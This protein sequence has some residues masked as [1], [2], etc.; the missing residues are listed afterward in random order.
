MTLP[1]IAVKRPIGTLMALVSVLVLGIIALVKLELAFMPEQQNKSLFVIANYQ[2]ASPKAIERMIVKPIEEVLASMNGVEHMWSNADS[3]GGRVVLNFS[4][5][6]NIDLARAEIHER[7]DRIKSELPEDLERLVIAGNWNPRETGET[8]M[9]ARLSSGRDLSKNYELLDRK[10]VKP[11]ERIPGVAV[12]TLDGVNPREVRIN[13]DLQ[14]LKRHKIDPRDVWQDIAQNNQNASIGILRNS[15]TKITLRSMGAL[16]SLEQIKALP[17]TG[18]SLVLSDVADITYQE[19]PLRYGRHLDGD[20]AI[21]LNVAK[22]SSANTIAITDAIYAKIEQMKSDPELDG[23]SFLVW[24]DQGKEIRNT[25]GDLQQTGFFG[26]ILASIVLFLFLRKVSTTIVAVACIPFSLIVACGVIW[27]QGK[28]LNTISLLGLIV[29]LGMLVDNAVVIMENIDRFQ[30]K[31]YDGRVAAILGAKE[32][33][34]AVITATLTSIIVFLPMIFSKPTNMN[35]IFQELGLTICF[36]LIASLL[37]SQTLIPLASTKLLRKPK[38]QPRTPIMDRLQSGYS[39]LLG[40]TLKHRWITFLIAIKLIAITIYSG[41]NIN[42]NLEPSSSEMHVG[43]RY[44]ISEPLSLEAKEELVY[45]VERALEPFKEKLKVKSIY[46]WWS[47]DRAITRLYMTSGYQNEEWMNKVRKELPSLLPEISGV[48]LKVEDNTP[49]WMRNRGKRVAMQLVGPD[50]ETLGKI[51]EE[52][53][54]RIEKIPGLFDFYSTAEGGRLELQAHLDRE[55]MSTYGVSVNQPASLVEMTFRGRNL[56]RFKS[57]NG[58]VEMR[59]MLGESENVYVSDVKNLSIS[60]NTG[61]NISLDSISEFVTKKGPSR[62]NRQNKISSIWVGARFSEGK[63]NEHQDKLVSVLNEIQL[64]EGYRWE[65]GGGWRGAE[66]SQ[67]EFLLNL[68]LAL[69]LIFAVMASLFESIRQALALMISSLF[70]L[71]GASFTLFLFE[72]DFDQPAGIA[73]LLLLGIV[74]NNG[75]VMIEHI[76]LYRRD[77][78]ERSKAMIQGGKERLRPIIMTALTTLV[79]LIPIVVQKPS[80][81]GV[82]YYS[83]AYVIIGG[84]LLSTV[85]TTVFLPATITLVEDFGSFIARI[86]GRFFRALRVIKPREVNS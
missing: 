85:L 2:N 52:A 46:S 14:K 47:E 48:N 26:A 50:S 60:K 11:L 40:F 4:L 8:I 13:L 10:I 33:S 36:S 55:K 32:V 72:I 39:S 62:I 57:E 38:I 19:P 61:E 70:A 6:T 25:L 30:K 1:E 23:I 9:E 68:A 51:G 35:I 21:G 24:Q 58:E 53:L 31:G 45:Q 7:V 63:R 22:E 42:F 16:K 17:L 5:E 37:I 56:P 67:M 81:G 83:M 41:S 43:V 12:V 80:L 65:M 86:I 76:N 34:I 27:L 84:L 66:E 44:D 3:R 78:W 69:G 15:Q 28:T 18:T 74:V 77:G 54:S 71:A 73:V 79:G 75:I 82:Y 64:P 29:G 49:F 59:L 20:F